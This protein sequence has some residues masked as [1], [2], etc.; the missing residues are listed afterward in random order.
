M[1]KQIMHSLWYFICV[2]HELN[3]IF[4]KDGKNGISKFYK[5]TRFMCFL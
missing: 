2:W 1:Q 3:F 5:E 4:K